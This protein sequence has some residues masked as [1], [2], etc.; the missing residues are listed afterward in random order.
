MDITFILPVT[1]QPRYWKRIN[2]LGKLG[3]NSKVLAFE[4]EYIPAS[5][6]NKNYVIIGKLEKRKYYKRIL[7]FIK[8]FTKVRNNIKQADIIY[9]FGLDLLFL[10]WVTRIFI[11][12]KNKIVYEVGDIRTV[13]MGNNIHSIFL[14]WLERV[15]MKHVGLLVVTSEAFVTEYFKKKQGI[16]N[17]NYQVLENKIIKEDFNK[18]VL[19]KHFKKNN[20]LIIG[21]FGLLNCTRTLEILKDIAIQ[22]GRNIEIHI[23]GLIINTKELM[24]EIEKISNIKYYGSYIA[25]DELPLIYGMIDIVWACY[26]SFNKNSISNLMWARPNRFYEACF[27][28]TPIITRKDTE[29]CREVNQYEIGICVD[30]RNISN[31][32]DNILKIDK[33]QLSIWRENIGKIP[34]NK[35]CYTTEHKLL[36]E[37]LIELKKDQ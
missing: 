16:K 23:R 4:R 30:P 2:S 15:L 33:K 1:S 36:Y 17:I 27:F 21:Y 10:V 28:K 14:R 34:E 35:F 5:K 25:P 19:K 13:L 7:P 31:V 12:K 3:C 6:N 37:K 9:V 11:N 24:E 20:V 22:G 8:V 29:V 32:V 18:L 26:Y